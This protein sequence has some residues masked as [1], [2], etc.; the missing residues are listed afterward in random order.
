VI[1]VAA[2]VQGVGKIDLQLERK[3]DGIRGG[4]KPA[5]M[6]KSQKS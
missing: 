1:K 6:S 4:S 5:K 3:M 2:G